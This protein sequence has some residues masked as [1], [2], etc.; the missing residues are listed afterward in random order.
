MIDKSIAFNGHKTITNVHWR[1]N[2][3]S[4]MVVEC[5]DQSLYIW[6]VSSRFSI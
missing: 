3:H 4:V 5:E 2:D 6:H 1:T